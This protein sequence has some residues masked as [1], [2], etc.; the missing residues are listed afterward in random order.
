[1]PVLIVAHAGQQIL[2]KVDLVLLAPFVEVL[3]AHLLLRGELGGRL[4]LPIVG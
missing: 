2:D 4:L 1:M 3:E